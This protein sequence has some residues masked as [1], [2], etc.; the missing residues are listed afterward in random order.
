MRHV[1]LISLGI[2]TR[3]GYELKGHNFELN[4]IKASRVV[5]QGTMKNGLYFLK[6]NVSPPLVTIMRLMWNQNCNFGTKDLHASMIGTFMKCKQR[7]LGTIKN[8]ID[9]L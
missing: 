3:E 6:G 4:V 9:V 2:L 1:N 8:K 7:L 5:F